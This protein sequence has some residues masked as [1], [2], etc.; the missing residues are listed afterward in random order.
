[1]YFK[2]VTA[3]NE[4]YFISLKFDAFLSFLIHT[5]KLFCKRRNVFTFP[6]RRAEKVLCAKIFSKK[7]TPVLKFV[8]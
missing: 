5:F 7:H 8:S 3:C 1:M 4:V 2:S 6:L